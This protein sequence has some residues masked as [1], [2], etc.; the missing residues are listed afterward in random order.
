MTENEK[1]ILKLLKRWSSL[2]KNLTATNKKNLAILLKGLAVLDKDEGQ[3]LWNVYYLKNNDVA[4]LSTFHGLSLSEFHEKQSHILGKM[5]EPIL[6][7]IEER[8]KKEIEEIRK[9]DEEK[10]RKKIER[11]EV[12]EYLGQIKFLDS[13]IQLLNEGMW[14]DHTESHYDE[15]VQKRIKIDTQINELENAKWRIIIRSQYVLNKTINEIASDFDC[16]SRS[17]YR[18]IDEAID[19]F[20]KILEKEQNNEPKH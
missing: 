11:R 15:L 3:L 6:A 10:E 5:E 2:S 4:F 7:A 8:K 1:I 14:L 16:S 17:V 9:N 13:E 20:A 18:I 19:N 12:R